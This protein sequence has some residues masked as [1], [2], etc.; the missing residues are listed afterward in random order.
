MIVV[1]ATLDKLGLKLNSRIFRR[2]RA[3]RISSVSG[4]GNPDYLYS[5]LVALSN[6]A[7]QD[8]RG[9]ELELDGEPRRKLCLKGRIRSWDR[10]KSFGFARRR[11]NRGVEEAEE[12]RLSKEQAK[13]IRGIPSMLEYIAECFKMA[14]V[15]SHGKTFTLMRL[16]NRR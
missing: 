1:R 9:V 15:S 10:T 13:H 6:S 12:N 7:F 14:T 5:R 4:I 3:R 8:R 2:A 11:W 16:E